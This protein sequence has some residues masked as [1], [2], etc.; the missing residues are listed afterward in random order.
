MIWYDDEDEDEMLYFE[1]KYFEII[2][3]Q[4][5][6]NKWDKLVHEELE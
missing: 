6:L 2:W 1:R 5:S 3:I 4:E